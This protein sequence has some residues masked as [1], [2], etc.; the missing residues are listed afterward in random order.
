MTETQARAEAQAIANRDGIVMAVTFDPWAEYETDR[1]GYCPEAAAA[2]CFPLEEV[3][4]TLHP[5]PGV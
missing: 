3:R 1:W 2:K 4:A 5:A